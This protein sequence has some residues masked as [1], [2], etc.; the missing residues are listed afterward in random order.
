MAQLIRSQHISSQHKKGVG[1]V[2]AGAA[3]T[4]NGKKAI[5]RMGCGVALLSSA[6]LDAQLQ[7]VRSTS[8]HSACIR[9]C[10]C[11]KSASCLQSIAEIR[12]TA[13]RASNEIN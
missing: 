1:D 5:I 2:R 9:I 7:A 6:L 12:T 10:D 3:V 8:I 13:T 4:R 11:H